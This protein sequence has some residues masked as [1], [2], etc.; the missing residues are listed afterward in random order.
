MLFFLQQMY[1]NLNIKKVFIF[2]R[3]T[4]GSR[5]L[6]QQYCQMF[7]ELLLLNYCV[8]LL[9]TPLYVF[10]GKNILSIEFSIVKANF[11][12]TLMNKAEDHV[13]SHQKGGNENLFLHGLSYASNKSDR[14]MLKHFR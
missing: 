12:Q 9:P 3:I 14:E 13:I 1:L 5:V 4:S 11:E 6:F 7:L 2:Q 10:V 8:S